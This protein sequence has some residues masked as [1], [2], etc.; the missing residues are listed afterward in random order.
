[1]GSIPARTSSK[2]KALLKGSTAAA[3]RF[4]SGT[5]GGIE[6]RMDR[7]EAAHE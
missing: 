6:S 4:P 1:V 2:V 3:E 7:L 5:V